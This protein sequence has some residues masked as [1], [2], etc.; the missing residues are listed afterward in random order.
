MILPIP[1]MCCYIYAQDMK[2]IAVCITSSLF[3]LVL[4][5]SAA[6]AIDRSA[7]V[8]SP[9]APVYKEMNESS[10]VLKIFESGSRL[11][12]EDEIGPWCRIRRAGMSEAMGY[13]KCEVLA[14]GPA[15][16]TQALKP[17][18]TPGPNSPKPL[19][20]PVAVEPMQRET[21]PGAR[22]IM[23]RTSWCGYCKKAEALLGELNVNLIQYDIEK[24][25][26]R[27]AEMKSLGGVGVPFIIIG[28]RHIKGYTEQGIIDALRDSYAR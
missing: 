2:T 26:R 24:D 25:K 20:A 27:G 21:F 5:A 22:V 7:S 9:V 15:V 10:V 19:P 23:Y 28:G 18:Y 17:S 3:A 13:V 16:G 1:L 11:T 12:V 8:R 4:F 6:D 14:F